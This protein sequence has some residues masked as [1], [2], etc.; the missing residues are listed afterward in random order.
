MCGAARSNPA[1]SSSSAI[2]G[3]H[4]GNAVLRAIRP[5][6]YPGA[7]ITRVARTAPA[8]SQVGQPV[9]RPPRLHARF[10]L[11][12]RPHR[13]WKALVAHSGWHLFFQERVASISI[14]FQRPVPSCAMSRSSS[15]VL[16]SIGAPKNAREDKQAPL[17][18]VHAVRQHPTP[19]ARRRRGRCPPP[20][21][22]RLVAILR[23]A[24]A[25]ESGSDLLVDHPPVHADVHHPRVRVAR[26]DGRKRLDV[27][28][29]F[30]EM[31]LRH[32]EFFLVNRL[33]QS[34]PETRECVVGPAGLEPATRP[35]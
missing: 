18:R 23:G 21:R 2:L 29:A 31:P 7:A 6:A 27:A 35:L 14:R 25:P 8:T 19:P 9:F 3:S 17:S 16:G 4:K 30:E 10:V 24:V 34:S 15:G 1:T 28:P 26:H 11:G 33:L 32:R 12:R 22:S 13:R 5:P 20:R